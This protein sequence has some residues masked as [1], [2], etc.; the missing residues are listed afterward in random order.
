MPG[1]K[2]GVA[3]SVYN[4]GAFVATNLNV[5]KG[6][7]KN[8]NPHVAVCC[9]DKETLEKLQ[10]LNIDSLVAGNDYAVNSKHDLRL[11]QYDC[12]KKSVN[13]AAVATDY[14]IHWHADAFAL[15][16]NVISAMARHMDDNGL[17]F[18]GRGLWKS[19]PCSKTPNGDIDDHFFM[20][21]SSHV[22]D[23]GIYDDNMIDPVKDMISAGM[24][25]EGIL[26]TLVQQF[27]DQNDIHIYS[28]MGE[29]EV[30]ESGRHDPR[31]P[32]GIPHRTLPPVNFD[33]QRKF[34]HC[35]DMEHL[36]RIFTEEGIDPSLI[37]R[38]L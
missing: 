25:S 18:T 9:N 30:L 26:A 8:L 36:A 35:D 1:L 5:F 24:C 7:W 33:H 38:T 14:V 28:D 29:C 21:K 22:R 15:D 19:Y 3:I 2:I 6:V 16:G 13:A 17:L 11:R 20:A 23:S 27:T 10:T 12:I 32:D 34:L 31:Y 37:V 4:K